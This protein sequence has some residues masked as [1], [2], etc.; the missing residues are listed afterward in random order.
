MASESNLSSFWGED[1]E[2][3]VTMT[4]ATVISGWSLQF[5]IKQLYSDPAPIFSIVSGLGITITDPTN[6]VFTITIPSALSQMLTKRRVYVWDCQR[7]DSGARTVLAYG[8]Y[9]ILPEVSL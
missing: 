2:I 8:N 5:S 3:T 7:V 1:V 9:T 6:G 4:P